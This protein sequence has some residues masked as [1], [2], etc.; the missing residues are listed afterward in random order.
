MELS[1]EEF[2]DDRIKEPSL[3]ALFMK[4]NM[5]LMENIDH[6]SF[7]KTVVYYEGIKRVEEKKISGTHKAEVWQVQK[8][9]LIDQMVFTLK[10]TKK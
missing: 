10:V 7:D 5:N 1:T 6:I 9:S 8:D 3:L 2:Y 4:I